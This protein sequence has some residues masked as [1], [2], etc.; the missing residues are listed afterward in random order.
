MVYYGYFYTIKQLRLQFRG[1]EEGG[2]LQDVTTPYCFEL[3]DAIFPLNSIQ[4]G[5]VCMR[6]GRGLESRQLHHIKHKVDNYTWYRTRK[7]Q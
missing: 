6:V 2:W 1:T 3:H 5:L 4:Q 7:E